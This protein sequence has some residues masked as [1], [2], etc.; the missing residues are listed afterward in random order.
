MLTLL[1]YVLRRQ[2]EVLG[3]SN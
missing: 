3:R 2:F 1:Q